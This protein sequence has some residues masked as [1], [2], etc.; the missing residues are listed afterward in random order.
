MQLNREKHWHFLE[1]EMKAESEAFVKK[2]ETRAD[3]LLLES[4][5]MFVGKFITFRDGEMVVKFS[6]TRNLPRKGEFL[7]CM[8]LPDMLRNYRNWADRTYKN[9]YDERFKGTECVAIWQSAIEDNRYS[10]VG[11]RRVDVD[12]ASIMEKLKDIVLV[13]APNRPPLEYIKNLQHLVL[14]DYSFS[15]SSILDGDFNIQPTTPI[16]LRDNV[17][18]FVLKQISLS[19]TLI[20]QGPPGTGKTYMIAELCEKLCL[21]GKSVLVSAMT[22]RALMEV[23]EKSMLKDLLSAGRILKTNMTV[24]E[25]QE[26][27]NLMPMKEI[28]PI[29]G[30]VVL[31]TYFVSSGFAV[32]LAEEQPFDYVILDEASQAL[33]AMFAISKKIGKKQLW[34]G[35]ICQL[36]PIVSLNDDIIEQSKYRYFINGLEM[37]SN[38]SANPNYQLVKTY[39]FGPR[40]ARYTGIF[41]NNTL[42]SNGVKFQ[43]IESLSN[44]LNDAGGPSL[45][46]TDM[47]LG[48]YAPEIMLKIVAFLV[49]A[50]LKDDD[51]KNVAVLSCMIK[52]IKSLQKAVLQTIGTKSNVLIETIARIQGL[53]TD[54]TILVIPN[55]SYI[56]SLEEHLFNVATSRAREHTIIIADK[57][58]F[59]Y[60]MMNEKVRAFLEELQKEQCVYIPQQRISGLLG[61]DIIMERDSLLEG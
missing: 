57:N 48:N 58:I 14:A 32:N 44:I 22:N 20:L 12:F 33:L 47:E 24:D 31:S 38:A 52:T 3:F 15:V 40:T 16:L 18:D 60:S 36:A 61:S 13:F 45:V 53:T 41:Y 25:R 4:Q 26:L 46:L 59:K 21:A 54:I 27:P 5:E 35:D 49:H 50:I 39:R 11:F 30:G 8:L 34:I 6:N 17:T 7:Y 43:R 42:I 2:F 56:R 10:L 29:N 37:L 1:D 23:A 9:L 19:D 28:L 51:K 55:L